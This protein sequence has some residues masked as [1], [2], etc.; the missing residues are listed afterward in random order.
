VPGALTCGPT[1][2]DDSS[3][4]LKQRGCAM[5]LIDYN[6]F[7]GL[8]AQERIGVLQAALVGRAFQIEVK[9]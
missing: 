1:V 9:G 3:Q 4:N 8:S 7:S 2:I 6:Q 5:D